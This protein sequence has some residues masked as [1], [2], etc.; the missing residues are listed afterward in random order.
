MGRFGGDFKGSAATDEQLSEGP[1]PPIERFPVAPAQETRHYLKRVLDQLGFPYQTVS[2]EIAIRVPVAWQVQVLVSSRAAKWRVVP[3]AAALGSPTCRKIEGA[4]I[5]V[6]TGAPEEYRLG[7]SVHRGSIALASLETVPAREILL[8]AR[9]HGARGVLLYHPRAS[10]VRAV[11]PDFRIPLP[12]ATIGLETATSLARTAGRARIS[13]E[14]EERGVAFENSFVRRGEGPF[15][16][17]VAG[18]LDSRPLRMGPSARSS[19][20]SVMLSLLAM[21]QAPA[22][23]RV[24]FAFL[25]GEEFGSVGWSRYLEGAQVDAAEASDLLV[26][27]HALGAGLSLGLEVDFL[28]EDKGGLQDLVL[29]T[30]EEA[31]LLAV[32][33]DIGEVAHGGSPGSPM[34]WPVV[35]VGGR[36]RQRR[37]CWDLKQAMPDRSA[38]SRL[39]RA[40]ATILREAKPEKAGG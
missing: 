39:V 33:R 10:T 24:T 19:S 6:G 5:D 35:A 29:R 18:D 20:L 21:F 28:G 11:A 2:L 14:R 3:S 27:L 36:P 1:Y 8:T 40:L 7:D 32:P 37:T 15:H 4:V 22:D 9:D 34:G 13:V 25:G 16:V 26:D 30:F 38:V 12:A 23:R 31:G 17:L